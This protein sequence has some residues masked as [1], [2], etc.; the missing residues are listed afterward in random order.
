MCVCGCVCV[1]KSLNIH[2]HCQSRRNF[3]DSYWDSC[4]LL[5]NLVNTFFWY[6][7]CNLLYEKQSFT[8]DLE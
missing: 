4:Y 7:E 2:L 1:F 3:H 6:L 5:P 8:L